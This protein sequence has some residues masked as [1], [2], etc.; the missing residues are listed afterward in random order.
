LLRF[1]RQEF[2]VKDISFIYFCIFFIEFILRTPSKIKINN[3]NIKIQPSCF[4]YI[5]KQVRIFTLKK[6]KN[7]FDLSQIAFGLIIVHTRTC[8]FTLIKKILSVSHHIKIKD[9]VLK[10]WIMKFKIN[11]SIWTVL[12]QLAQSLSSCSWLDGF[13]AKYH[14]Y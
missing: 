1:R 9:R 5:F 14:Y 8:D 12:M 4:M 6:N 10:K 2:K 7:I 3:F 13:N 11:N